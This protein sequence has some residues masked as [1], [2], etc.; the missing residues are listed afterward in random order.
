MSE[1]P[2][3]WQ[4]LF[5][6]FLI[7]LNAMFACAEIAVISM[8][9]VKIQKMSEMG[10]KRAIKLEKLTSQPSRF[11]STIQVG[12]TLSGFMG[13]AFAADNFSDKLAQ[14]VSKLGMP[15]STSILNSI[16]VVI[17]TLILSYFT[18]VF[19]ELVPK[20]IAMKKTEQLALAMSGLIYTLSRIFVPIVSTLTASTNAILKLLGIDASA[21]DS[22]ITEEEIRMMVDVGEENG[23]IPENEKMMINNIFEFNDL[24]VSRIMTHRTDVVAVEK[25][26]LF[27]EIVKIASENGYSRLP[28][29]DNNTDNI[30]GIL[31]TKSLL[32][33]VGEMQARPFN[34][35][36][37][38]IKPYFV[39]QS[40]MA[41]DLFNEMQKNKIHMAIVVDEYGGTSGIVTMEDL[42][43]SVMGNIQDEYDEEEN[44]AEIIDE[45]T[46]V[47]DGGADFDTICDI[48]GLLV[49][50]EAHFD[51]DTLGGFVT[52]LLDKIPEKGD[53][54]EFQGFKFDIIQADDKRINKVKIIKPIKE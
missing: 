24:T 54:F 34:I 7:A 31:H 43:E 28:V 14:Y 53:K 50:E 1:D 11:L 52:S 38:L 46:F 51:Y 40:K 39:P 22:E 8:N 18:L 47:I 12:I 13:S 49:P 23:V 30:I 9:D 37:Y 15:I 36:N 32:E 26:T 10:D 44:E 41:D 33:Y 2:L 3:L 42:I 5:Q 16:S 4:I 45:H 17:I 21:N 35:E 20:R 29:Y 27:T 6:I 19:G 48:I 25:D